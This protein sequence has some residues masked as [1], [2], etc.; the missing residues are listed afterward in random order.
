VL[1]QTGQHLLHELPDSAL[2][3]TPR[4]G[5]DSPDTGRRSCLLTLSGW[6]ITSCFESAAQ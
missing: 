6:A 2:R 5:S 3:V 1:E 4:S